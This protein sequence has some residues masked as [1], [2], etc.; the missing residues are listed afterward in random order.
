V[1]RGRGV[2]INS[3]FGGFVATVCE[4]EV[5]PATGRVWPRRVFVA[6]DCGLIINP[7]GLRTTIEGNIVQGISRTLYEEVQFD[8]RNV[9]SVDWTSY[10][11]LEIGDAPEAIEIE[12]INRPDRP[13]GGAGEPAHVTVPAALGNALFD[14]TGVRVRRLPLSP[15]RVR[16]S[17]A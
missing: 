2:A 8:Q 4:V 6:H 5:E 1:L 11:I 16:A 12:L 14:A 13:P 17:L 7:Q 10:P 9:L 3:G 15:E